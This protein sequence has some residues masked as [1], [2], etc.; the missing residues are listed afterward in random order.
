MP[1]ECTKLHTTFLKFPRDNKHSQTWAI[2]TSKEKGRERRRVDWKRWEEPL[3]FWE[4]SCANGALPCVTASVML[5]CK[6]G[7]FWCIWAILAC[8][9]AKSDLY[10]S[11]PASNLGYLLLS[12]DSSQEIAHL[13]DYHERFR[14]RV[15]SVHFGG[16][17]LKLL[18]YPIKVLTLQMSLTKPWL[19]DVVFSTDH[20]NCVI[21]LI[22]HCR[23]WRSYLQ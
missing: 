18:K 12:H 11:H 21:P 9:H 14:S 13:V 6:M 1:P 22:G 17:G 5:S 23:W 19:R 16:I 4:R 3:H 15:F 2:P 20:F 7:P 8:C 10:R